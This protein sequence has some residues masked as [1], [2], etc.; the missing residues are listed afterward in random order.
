M[1]PCRCKCKPRGYG[2]CK[3]LYSEQ[4]TLELLRQLGLH[5]NRAHLECSRHLYHLRPSQRSGLKRYKRMGLDLSSEPALPQSRV[6]L[7][8]VHR[9]NHSLR[10][11]SVRP[12]YHRRLQPNIAVRSYNS[13]LRSRNHILKSSSQG[14]PPISLHPPSMPMCPRKLFPQIFLSCCCQQ[15]TST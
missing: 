7:S 2:M 10:C 9:C 4:A 6:S 8:I 15:Q 5:T 13:R 14:P 12:P 11:N 3:S 1:L